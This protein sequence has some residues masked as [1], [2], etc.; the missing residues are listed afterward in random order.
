VA[1]DSRGTSGGL[2]FNATLLAPNFIAANSVLNGIHPMPIQNTGGEGAVSGEE[3]QFDVTLT[4]TI[5]LAAGQYFF[6]PQVKLSSGD[7]YWLSAAGPTL[8][9][10]LQ[11]WI[12]NA[13]LAPDWLQVGS[14][15][16][17]GAAKFNGSLALLGTRV[18]KT[19]LPLIR[20]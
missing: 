1:F 20:R 16:V 11:A 19:F 12:R 15:I 7:F 14:D 17:G 9:G 3:V 2:N 4:P 8:P 10:D 5:E 13:N 6:V 18:L